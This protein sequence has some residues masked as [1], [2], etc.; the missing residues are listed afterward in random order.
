M[1]QR[2]V[3]VNNA[4]EHC[5]EA[6]AGVETDPRLP[7]RRLARDD[8]GYGAKPRLEFRIARI[9]L[10]APERV[11]EVKNAQQENDRCA[12]GNQHWCRIRHRVDSGGLAAYTRSA[13]L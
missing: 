2:E 1:G 4:K 13:C 5:T 11:D 7:H 8:W 3:S 6:V 10:A 12:R 9:E